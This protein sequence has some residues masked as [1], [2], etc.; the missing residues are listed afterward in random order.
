MSRYQRSIQIAFDEISGEIIKAEDEFKN[1]TNAFQLR[2][3]FSSGLIKLQCFECGEGLNVSGSKYDRLHFKHHPHSPDCILKELSPKELDE[4]TSILH[5]KESA[6]HKELKNKI[7]RSLSSVDGVDPNSIFVDN[8]F[9]IRGSDKRR[10]DVYCK[11]LEKELGFEIQLSDL[12]QRYILHRH[13][14]YKKNGMYLIWILDNFDV[15][16]QSQTE[17]DIK[18]LTDYQN[19][20]SLDETTENFRLKCEYKYPFLTDDHKV[21]T[22]WLS[23]SVSL[24][25][26]RYDSEDFQAYYYDFRNNKSKIEEQQR[27]VLQK[28]KEDEKKRIKTEKIE[29]AQD[30][31]NG[32]IEEI[33]NAKESA[34]I[35]YERIDK[36][37]RTLDD[38]TLEMLNAKLKLKTRLK[39]DKHIVNFWLSPASDKDYDF[40][41]FI[42]RCVEIDMEVNWRDPH[43][44]SCLQ[45][46]YNNPNIHKSTLAILIFQ[47]GFIM[48]ETDK[49]FLNEKINREELNRNI[50]FLYSMAE[51][52]SDKNLV[53]DIF[54]FEKLIYI[55]ESIRQ[56]KIIGFNYKP[57]EWV[58]FANNA[59]QYHAEHWEYIEHAFKNYELWDHIISL[60]KKETFQ[61][62]LQNLYANFPVQKFDVE[63]LIEELYP[64]LSQA[65]EAYVG[66][67]D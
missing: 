3:K 29:T 27:I 55:I 41:H 25:D 61:K 38:F 9:I 14:F 28:L 6:R 15:H 63:N 36:R 23:N 26:L 50:L 11:Y 67:D 58:A 17:R 37:I 32:I 40:L 60:D 2:T 57:T 65:E 4:F 53:P 21:L 13:N 62:K 18:Y 5:V 22:K 51:Q 35:S 59:I 8:K 24:S 33:K 39:E 54:R 34:L 66:I 31:V 12:S 43:N 1:A 49:E 19:Y 10:P 44:E 56:K 48:N 42:L 20:F 45:V 46:L 47:R 7:A 30:I 52:I 64:N 16:G